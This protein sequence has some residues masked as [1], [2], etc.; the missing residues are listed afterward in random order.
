MIGIVDLDRAEADLTAGKLRCPGCGGVL[1]RWG[2]GRARRVRDRGSTTLNV[3]PR[4]ARCAGCGTTQVL[5]PGELLPRRADTTAVIGMALLASSRGTGYRHIAADIGR[6]LST[7]PALDPFDVGR[8]H[9]AAP[10]SGRGVDLSCRPRGVRHRRPRA[11][12]ARGCAGRARGGRGDR[13]GQARPACPALD[14]DR[15]A[16]AMAARRAGR[17]S[18]LTHATCSGLR[19]PAI[20]R[21]RADDQLRPAQDGAK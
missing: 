21:H 10:P 17:P 14:V 6:P 8:V 16:H 20:C 3:R 5:L 9:R 19:V 12:P 18:R 7:G 2:H 13:A 1:R 4:R 11:D 15:P